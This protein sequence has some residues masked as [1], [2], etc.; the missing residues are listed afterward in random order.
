[1]TFRDFLM[2]FVCVS[3]FLGGSAV[4]QQAGT[5]SGP[6]SGKNVE[7]STATE[8][9]YQGNQNG[10]P[11]GAGSPGVEAKPGTEGGKAQQP[12]K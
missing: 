11:V 9:T 6:S 10:A 4:A 12:G 5:T 2:F 1:M 8:K 3:L 7:P